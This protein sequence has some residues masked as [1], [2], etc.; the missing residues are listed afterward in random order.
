M[1]RHR[2]EVVVILA[3]LIGAAGSACWAAEPRP[4]PDQIRFFEASVRPVLAENCYK[5]HGPRK[6]RGGL[7]LDSRASVLRGGDSGP[8]VVPGKPGQSLL[9][10]AVRRLSRRKMPP[11]A[12]LKDA[13]VAALITWVRM[14]APWPPGDESQVVRPAG[15]ITDEDRAYWAFQPVRCPRIPPAADTGWCRNA[16]D[17]FMLQ[18]MRLAGLAPAPE[19]SKETLIRR[20]SFD[21]IGL[22]PTPREIDAF[23]ADHSADAYE[24]MVDRL[25]ASSRH[26]ERWARHWLDL[27]RYADSDGYNLDDYRPQAWHFR[28]YVIRSFNAD[29]PY[30]RFVQEQLAGDELFPGDPEALTAT[31]YLRHGIYEY[32]SRDVRGQWNIILN[33]I[34]DTTGDVFLGLGIQ[35]ARCHDHKF[36]PILREDYYRLQAFFAPILPRDDLP[37]A[38]ATQIKQYQARLAAWEARTAHLRKQI[39]KIE[40]PY[41]RQAERE[42]MRRLPADIQAL[43]RT[44]P[45]RRAP[46]EHQWAELAY[47]QVTFEYDRLDR[48]LKGADKQKVEALR[49]QLA[50]F[51]P[52]KP[53]PLPQVMAV[54][55]VGREPPPLTMPRRGKRPVQPGFPTILEKEPARISLLPAAPRSTGRRAALARWLTRPDHPLTSRVIVNRIWQ[56]HFGRGLAANPSDFGKLGSKPTHPELLDWLA[57]R[58]VRD[59]WNFKRL[60]R[61]IVTS[62]TYRQAS[63]HPRP[64]RCRR[65]DPE[66]LLHW[67]GGIRRLDAEQIRD[68]LLAVTGRLKNRSGGPGEDTSQPRRTIYTRVMRNTRDPL[69]D[70][71][72]LPLFFSSIASRDTT[73]TPVQSLLLFNSQAM[74]LHARE[75]ARRLESERPQQTRGQVELAYRLAFGRVPGAEEAAAALRFL[76]DQSGRIGSARSGPQNTDRARTAALVDF[77]HVLLNSSEFLYVD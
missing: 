34:T 20:L 27:V 24:K 64:D 10:E 77:C 43:I 69:L 4:A 11:E 41:R 57:A 54:T 19:A 32:N 5:C 56:Y 18:R 7:R 30:D 36:D 76:H 63:G 71:F 61:L 6:Q 74:Q 60:H 68:P 29:K 2:P 25:L 45:A 3:W 53:E 28:D 22:P 37:A 35:C 48:R 39:E 49:K 9:V 46:L 75:W 33:D 55:D 62:A 15:T 42:A 8:A 66:N 13:E 59:G 58:F 1:S 23:L 65:Q 72:D 47:R 12:K 52:E 51:D 73:T 21:L 67:R 70:V 44:P 31:G 26:G 50:D 17:R 14:G 38:T 40:L 16:I